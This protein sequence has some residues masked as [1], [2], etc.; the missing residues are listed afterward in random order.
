LKSIW[1]SVGYINYTLALNAWIMAV[2]YIIV[3]FVKAYQT[4][5]SLQ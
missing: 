5:E 4:V 2:K 1:A 3:Y